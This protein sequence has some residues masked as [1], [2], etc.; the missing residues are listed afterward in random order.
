MLRRTQEVIMKAYN[1]Q[2]ELSFGTIQSPVVGAETG[3][4]R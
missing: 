2:W 3:S 1:R 4:S